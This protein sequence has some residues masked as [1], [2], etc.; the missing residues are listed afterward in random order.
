MKHTRLLFALSLLLLAWVIPVTAGPLA[1][2]VS[3]HGHDTAAG[4][5]K[6]PLATLAGARDR[7]RALKR[8][9]RLP[10]TGATV[11]LLP[12]TYQ[13][14]ST[15]A[16]TAADDLSP[17]P[18]TYEAFVV[19]PKD[20]VHLTG[21]AE[22]KN[23]KP[24]LDPAVLSRLDPAARG[25]VLQADLRAQGI[26]DYGVMTGRGFSR[27]ITP[28]GMELFF[29]DKPMTLARWPNTGQWGS[30][31][32][33]PAG[34]NGDRFAYSGERP[35]RWAKDEDI[36]VHG[37]WTFD[38]ADTYEK[39]AAIDPAKHEI[40]IAPPQGPFGYTTGHHWYALNVLEELDT[41]GEW[42]LDRKH[43][44]LYFWPPSDVAKG[45]PIVSTL[46][47]LIHLD[48]VSHVTLRGL[49][50]EACQGKGVTIDG[51]D[52]NLIAGC[53]I[54]NTGNQAQL[55]RADRTMACKTATSPRP[56]TAA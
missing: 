1:L 33:T 22:V 39:V 3:P 23:W 25:H 18:I 47:D 14:K 48:H 20:T 16:L 45:H 46:Q 38:W 21:G 31:A 5:L 29:Q 53:T 40:V 4:S 30:I 34:Q 37:Y 41:P 8:A 35:A 28:A 10:R 49:T 52:H 9:G 11:F 19:S 12:G 17:L 27:P 36:W 43:G 2:Y 6:A 55:L 32:G 50:L 15:F 7:L 51:G 42:Y 54:R 13:L 56:A 24:V 44:I 26:T